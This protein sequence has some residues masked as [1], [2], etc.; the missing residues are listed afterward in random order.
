MSQT[1][2]LNLAAPSRA[3]PA[4]G[5]LPWRRRRGTLQV[6]MVHRPRYDD[7]SWAKGKLDAGEEWP[8]AAVREVAEETALDVHLGIPL[9][10]SEYPVASPEGV[11]T[12][13][14]RYWA[15]EVVG[16]DGKLVNEI[17]EVAW[18]DPVE[19][20]LRLDYARDQ[21][22]LRALV[23][24][25]ERGHLGTWALAFVRHAKARPRGSWR[26]EDPSRPLDARGQARARQLAPM[27][28]AFGVRRLVSSPS[29]R[30][31]DTLRP[32][33]ASERIPLR[34]KIGL[35]EEGHDADPPKAAY[36]VERMLQRGTSVA[37]CG[38]G[39]VLPAMIGAILERAEGP[40]AD[41]LHEAADLGLA[42]GE[43]LVTHLS[44][45]GE[46]A[47]VAAVERHAPSD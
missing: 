27:L 12:K 19:A 38:H 28:A 10:T 44:G 8:V 34:C 24:A 26:G 29:T 21:E 13:T 20:A 2:P 1:A 25:D 45:T 9:P 43:L 32:Y 15:A 35:S 17:D 41:V 23:Q 3:T 46:S 11:F 37:V 40:A 36:H 14:V 39:P 18:L 31:V 7:W 5:A 30:C 22:Q 33:A 47:R 4:A 6:A 16:G 42:K